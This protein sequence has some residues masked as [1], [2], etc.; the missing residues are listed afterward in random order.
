[1]SHARFLPI[2]LILGLPL[3][4]GWAQESVMPPVPDAPAAEAEPEPEP[5]EADLR[6]ERAIERLD[7]VERASA[8]IVQEVE[9]FDR[10]FTIV[11][12]YLKG[13]PLA[14][15]MTLEIQG[16]PETTGEMA[17]ISDG[18]VLWDYQRILG[19]ANYFRMELPPVMERLEDPIFPEEMR[20][21]FE[22][23]QLGLS[24]PKALLEGL[25]ETV[26]FDR[27]E[28]GELD[29]RPV[30]ILRGRWRDTSSLGLQPLAP[31][32]SYVPSLVTVWLD[33]EN[34][35]PLQVLLVGKQSSIL[36]QSAQQPRIDPA[37][38]RPIGNIVAE[39]EPP[40]RFR[41]RYEQIDFD[42]EIPEG[43]FSFRV[44][45]DA[46]DRLVDTTE[47]ILNQLEMQARSLA[48][49]QEQGEDPESMRDLLDVPPI[50]ATPPSDP[51]QAPG[52]TPLPDGP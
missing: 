34:G 1:M 7:Q 33:T 20:I 29:G 51:T 23:Q 39:Q 24:G 49:M 50:D 36:A 26:R 9:M 37:T 13:G 27:M 6:L 48:A 14:F 38:G 18:R 45:D 31:V 25:R 35:W 2:P 8:R 15:R 22:R 4:I 43:A 30:V 28:E 46:R 44:P 32:P 10:E 41:L 5:T 12:E 11:G 42:P 3:L 47:T 40:S 17:Q 21:A 52:P 16:L 19:E